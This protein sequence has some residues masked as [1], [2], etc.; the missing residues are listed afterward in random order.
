MKGQMIVTMVLMMLSLM[1]VRKAI[2]IPGMM[3]Y[4][5]M[6]LRRSTLT[7]TGDAMKTNDAEVMMGYPT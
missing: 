2:M 6:N 3:L 5:A 4:M 1:T 7:T